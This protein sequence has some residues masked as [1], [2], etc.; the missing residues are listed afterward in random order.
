MWET[1]QVWGTI[2]FHSIFFSYYGSQWCPKTAWLQTFF[3]IS[4]FVF[5]RTN[6]FIKVWNYWRGSKWWQNFHFW[7]NYPF[8]TRLLHRD[9]SYKITKVPGHKY[10]CFSFIYL[11]SPF[12][13]CWNVKHKVSLFW[14][15]STFRV[16]HLYREHFQLLYLLTTDW[17]VV[18]IL[19]CLYADACCG[20]QTASSRT[21]NIT[22]SHMAIFKGRCPRGLWSLPIYDVLV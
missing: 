8:N 18:I 10:A 2:D 5:N 17:R 1:E 11:F 3:K 9:S 7:V 13:I 14:V 20:M 22:G 21:L 4:C 19:I 16:V 15:V 6:K 12:K